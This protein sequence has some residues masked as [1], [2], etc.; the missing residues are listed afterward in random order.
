[1]TDKMRFIEFFFLKLLKEK[2]KNILE[3]SGKT[4]GI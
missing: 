4:Q 3:I 1:M 2:V